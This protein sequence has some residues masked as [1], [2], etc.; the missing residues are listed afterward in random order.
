MVFRRPYGTR[1][2]L[3]EAK[4]FGHEKGA[5]TGA[6]QQRIGRFE[7]A[8]LGTLFLDEVGEISPYVQ[9]KVLRVIEQRRFERL[10]SNRTIAVDVRV[11]A[12]TNRDLKALVE[13]SKFRDDLYWRLNVI[14]IQRKEDIP[15]L[16]DHFIR[17]YAERNAKE[18]LG[19][20]R[21]ALEK[22]IAYDY[23]GNVRE[24]ENIIERTVV[25]CT[26]RVIRTEDLPAELG[27]SQ[28]RGW[29][30]VPIGTSMKDVEKRMIEETV[31]YTGG[32]ARRA[33]SSTP[34]G[35][36]SVPSYCGSRTLPA[37]R[38]SSIA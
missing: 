29:I 12:A 36:L 25:L 33:P 14:K 34:R 26:G 4:L 8:N 19:I 37:F 30:P 27:G 2:V 16:A 9:T 10:G 3:L 18:V 24:L 11:I 13:E 7:L 28:K 32:D 6:L 5:F 35:T 17:K 38:S 1:L 20:S 15:P 21:E 22:L 23:P 31:R